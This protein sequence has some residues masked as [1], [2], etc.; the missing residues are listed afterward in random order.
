VVVASA[1]DYALA[2]PARRVEPVGDD[3][4][5][6]AAA[7]DAVAHAVADAQHVVARA[8]V[9]QVAALAADERVVPGAAVE[10]VVAREPRIV[11]PPPS[12]RSVS[13]SGVPTSRSAARSRGRAV[14]WTATARERWAPPAARRA[15][16]SAER[17]RACPPELP[18]GFGDSD[19]GAGA[20]TV[21]AEE[22][23]AVRPAS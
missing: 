1:Q 11:S 12:P 20:V 8:A 6:S 2:V 18:P 14:C 5:T 10:Q 17:D 9:E 23:V 21:N 19:G 16:R 3:A 15:G 4:V 7:R 13:R 22:L